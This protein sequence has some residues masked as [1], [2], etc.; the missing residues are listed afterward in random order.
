MQENEQPERRDAKAC[1]QLMYAV[2]PSELHSCIHSIQRCI[3]PGTTISVDQEIAIIGMV[4]D[5]TE[6][7]KQPN[8]RTMLEVAIIAT[9]INSCK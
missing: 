7:M 5:V 2:T 1:F 8:P 9:F 3:N 4:R 6:A